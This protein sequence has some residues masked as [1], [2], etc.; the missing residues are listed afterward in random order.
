MVADIMTPQE[1]ADEALREAGRAALGWRAVVTYSDRAD[2]LVAALNDL[3]VAKRT[4][5]D[6]ERDYEAAIEAA[7]DERR[8]DI[9]G[10]GAV[11]VHRSA[12]R[13]GWD[14][15]AMESEFI[16]SFPESM[17][18]VAGAVALRFRRCFSVGGAKAGFTE[19]T[20]RDLDEFC[21]ESWRTS[22]RINTPQ[23]AKR[24]EGF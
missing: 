5:T 18:D 19:M 6:L 13:T 14:H 3:R 23:G 2:V 15:D 8:F 12:R 24:L 21:T 7:S 4:L 11:E 10:L 20:G 1:H 22:V 9:D 16:R 17:R